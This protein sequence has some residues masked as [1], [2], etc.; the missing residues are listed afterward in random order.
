MR[1]LDEIKNWSMR[2]R[3]WETLLTRYSSRSVRSANKGG[4]L[5][6]DTKS[7]SGIAGVAAEAGHCG[8]EAA[9]ERLLSLRAVCS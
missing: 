8:D 5:G 3:P 7:Q 6:S 1:K 2:V 9:T 4:A